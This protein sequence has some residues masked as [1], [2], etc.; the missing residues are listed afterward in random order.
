[1]VHN[2]QSHASH[3]SSG[4]SGLMCGAVLAVSAQYIQSMLLQRGSRTALL[5]LPMDIG[6]TAAAKLGSSM[7]EFAV[8][9][10]GQRCVT[11]LLASH[12]LTSPPAETLAVGS[13]CRSCLAGLPAMQQS[14]R[15]S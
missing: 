14:S 11:A 3:L 5:P 15:S 9:L 4:L 10:T 13:S 2:S 7:L 8:V 1:M 6:L 12:L